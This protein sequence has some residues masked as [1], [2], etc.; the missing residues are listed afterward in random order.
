[1]RQQ[2]AKAMNP[3]VS[4]AQTSSDA[5]NM[6]RSRTGDGVDMPPHQQAGMMPMHPGTPYGH[7][8]HH[9]V[10]GVPHPQGVPNAMVKPEGPRMLPPGGMNGA[11]MQS[12]GPVMSN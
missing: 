10:P 9:P 11:G 4:Q 7:P 5:A 6:S 1:M 3:G 2:Q 8:Q 12:N